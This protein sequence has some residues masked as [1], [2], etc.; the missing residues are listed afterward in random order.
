MFEI[1]PQQQKETP[2]RV[3]IHQW[4]EVLDVVFTSED[5][6]F[7]V[8]MLLSGASKRTDFLRTLKNARNQKRPSMRS[9]L[10]C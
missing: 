6:C 8:T 7:H 3:I 5:L 10:H 1:D 9:S 4:Y 2:Q